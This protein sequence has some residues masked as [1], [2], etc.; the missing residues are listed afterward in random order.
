MQSFFKILRLNQVYNL[1]YMKEHSNPVISPNWNLNV[2]LL[3]DAEIF[4]GI[5][6]I[7]SILLIGV[8]N[9]HFQRSFL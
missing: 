2:I 9:W 7:L 1:V 3:Q 6:L 5:V 4:N 8:S